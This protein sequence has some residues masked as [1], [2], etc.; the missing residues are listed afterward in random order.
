VKKSALFLLVCLTA[1][2]Q[3]FEVASVKLSPPGTIRSQVKGGPESSNPGQITYTGITLTDLLRRAYSVQ[4]QQVAGPR[5]LE[6]ER[7]DIVAKLPPGTVKKDLAPM[8]EIFLQER[9]GLAA[10]REVRTMPVYALL[11]APDGTK[12]KATPKNADSSEKDA[13][14]SESK[15]IDQVSV[16]LGKDGN[17]VMPKG[18]RG[19]MIGMVVAGKYFVRFKGETMAEFARFLTE[20][21]DHVVIDATGLTETY[22]FAASWQLD[23]TSPILAGLTMAPPTEG[24]L[25]DPSPTLFAALPGQLGLKF[26]SRKSPLEMVVVDRVERVPTEN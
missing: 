26:E 25:S 20:Q 7:Y 14:A 1:M 3:H 15:A 10:H 4:R 8:L 17:V 9:F 18:Y 22:D 12:F 11:V 16:G 13:P 6:E 24:I 23:P 19:T 5:W 21:T 2:A